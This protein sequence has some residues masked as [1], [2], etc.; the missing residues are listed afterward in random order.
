MMGEVVG[1][2]VMLRFGLG[3]FVSLVGEVDKLHSGHVSGPRALSS[4]KTLG[5]GDEVWPSIPIV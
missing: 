4:P 2:L 5:R 1:G 3:G